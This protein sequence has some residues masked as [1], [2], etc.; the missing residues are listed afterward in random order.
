MRG[1]FEVDVIVPNAEPVLHVV[2]GFA[3][4]G[5]F[6]TLKNSARTRILA[7]PSS[8]NARSTAISISRCPG[9]RTMPTPLLPK[10]VSAGL[11]PNGASGAEVNAAGLMY[12]FITREN[13]DP[14]VAHG[15]PR[16]L[17]AMLERV[18]P[19]HRPRIVVDDRQRRPRLRH[20]NRRHLPTRQRLAR[21]PRPPSQL[22]VL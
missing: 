19:V 3:K 5:V 14:V 20:R 11:L 13:S 8:A 7:V 2:S 15:M 1:L 4:F 16:Q 10:S 12:P 18:R 17:R 21:Q 9:P 6:V 22:G